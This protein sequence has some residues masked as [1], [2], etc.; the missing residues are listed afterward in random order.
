MKSIMQYSIVLFVLLPTPLPQDDMQGFSL[1]FFPI[2]FYFYK[3]YCNYCSQ[4]SQ[5]VLVA[6]NLSANAGDV[7]D[8]SLIPGSGKS[9]QKGMTTHSSILAWRIPQT[10][11]PGGLQFIGLQRDTTE[12]TQ[13]SCLHT[14]LST[15]RV[16]G[17]VTRQKSCLKILSSVLLDIAQL[18]QF[19]LLPAYMRAPVY[20]ILMY[21]WN[22]QL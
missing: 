11:E 4:A 17:Y 8:L 20:P 5:V 18:N 21:P 19:P 14:I 12:V 3:Q 15:H 7:R 1:F 16:L 6:R 13:H 22:Y 9:L 2:Y 10:E